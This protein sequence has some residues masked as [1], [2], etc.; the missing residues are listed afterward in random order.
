MKISQ[1]TDYASVLLPDGR[2]AL[3]RGFTATTI[4]RGIPIEMRVEV[5]DLG[6]PRCVKLVICARGEDRVTG[7]LLRKIP[8]G[9]LVREA[10][11]T[12]AVTSV[13]RTPG[14]GERGNFLVPPE[15]AGVYKQ[16]ASLERK[17]RKGSP[18]A[19]EDLRAIAKNYRKALAADMPP[20]QTLA[21][22]MGVS[23]ATAS[24]WVAKARKRGFLGPAKPG[25][26]SA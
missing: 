10:V 24:Q 11:A 7:G 9:R 22:G 1:I 2:T 8:V 23:R 13:R 6:R 18:L 21:V 12:A 4:E 3:P 19:D 15:M 25:R 17:P 26:A 16:F 20:T 5:D 14:G